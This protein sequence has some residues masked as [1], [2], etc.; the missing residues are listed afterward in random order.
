MIS[1][2]RLNSVFIELGEIAE[3]TLLLS[4]QNKVSYILSLEIEGPSDNLSP[5]ESAEKIL[6]LL[7]H[8]L[9]INISLKTN[10]NHVLQVFVK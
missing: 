5:P 2:S 1:N 7:A 3:K 9:S 10:E 8:L 6:A 4:L